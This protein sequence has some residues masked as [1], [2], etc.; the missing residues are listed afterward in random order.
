AAPVTGP[1]PRPNPE[2][3]RTL[4]GERRGPLLAAIDR[5]VTAAGSRLLAQRLSA[6]LTDPAAIARRHDAVAAFVADPAVRADLREQLAAA[7][8]LARSLARLAVGRGG[9]RDPAAIRDGLP[10][11]RPTPAPLSPPPH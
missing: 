2:L 3:V 7:P 11:A 10:A 9:P 8:D 4:A 1:R 5:S 6:P